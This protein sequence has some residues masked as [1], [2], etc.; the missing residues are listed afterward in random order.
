LAVVHP[1]QAV[2]LAVEQVAARA[3]V[4]EAAPEEEPPR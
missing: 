1:R 3:E 4:P 2:V